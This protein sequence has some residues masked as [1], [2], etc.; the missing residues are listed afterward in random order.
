MLFVLCGIQGSGKT[1]VAKLIESMGAKRY[2]H[3]ELI[4]DNISKAQMHQRAVDELIKG[5]SVVLDA[6]YTTKNQRKQVLFDVAN[7]SCKKVVIVMNTPY[8]E[9][10]RRNAKREKPIPQRSIE[11]TKSLYQLPTYDEGWDEIII[12]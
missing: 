5:N 1:T 9:C 11:Y 12:V 6:I 10:L 4:A 3:D 8:D 2:S 7:I